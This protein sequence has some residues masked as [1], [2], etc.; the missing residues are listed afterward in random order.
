MRSCGN[1][2]L[3]RSLGRP[4]RP[5]FRA[6]TRLE[7]PTLSVTEDQSITDEQRGVA[8]EPTSAAEGPSLAAERTSA[9]ERPS[10]TGAQSI[11]EDH[12]N[13]RD[14]RR[15]AVTGAVVDA[16]R[17][18]GVRLVG[19]LGALVTARLLTPYDFGLV[20]IGTTVLAFGSLLDDGGVGTALIRRPEPP[21]KVRAPGAGCVSVWARTDPGCGR[22]PRD[23]AV[24]LARAGHDGD[25]RLS[26]TG[27]VPRA[28][29]HPLRTSVEL[30]TD[31]H[32]RHRPDKRLLRV[33][34]RD[35]QHRLGRVGTR[36]RRPRSARWPD[37][38]SCSRSYRRD[39]SRRCHRGRRYDLCSASAFA[40]RP[41]ASCICCAT[42]A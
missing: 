27:R 34:N 16:L 14:V 6:S 40:F 12:L 5:S 35:D 7:S 28:C 15:R 10:V 21:T 17:A 25:R 23:A 41:S 22:R 38:C 3:P 9:A 13:A 33:G 42:K 26:P 20:A 2:A 1:A 19:L 24:R 4:G 36:D 39:E 8:A 30:P 29:H 37:W 31:G 32:R 11:A 18:I